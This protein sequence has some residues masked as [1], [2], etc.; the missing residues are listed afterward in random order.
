MTQLAQRRAPIITSTLCAVLV[1]C[2]GISTL[3]WATNSLSVWTAEEARRLRVLGD[4]SELPDSLLLNH[5]QHPRTIAGS[6]Q[7]FVVLNFIYTRCPT[8]CSTLGFRFKQLQDTLYELGLADQVEMLSISFDLKHDSPEMLNDYLTW[9]QADDRV[10]SALVPQSTQTLDAL[11]QRF[12]VVVI[13][14]EFGGYTHN[15]AIYVIEQGRLK[16]IFND[17]EIDNAIAYIIANSAH[18]IPIQAKR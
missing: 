8:V 2:L 18:Q 7:P 14:D 17:D 15:A 16:K 10:W 9:H 1:T 4:T 6:S 3:S 5:R 12:G 11:I 13:D